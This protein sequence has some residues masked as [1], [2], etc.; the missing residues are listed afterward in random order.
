METEAP[1]PESPRDEPAVRPSTVTSLVVVAETV[2]SKRAVALVT[3][4]A[5]R[6]LMAVPAGLVIGVARGVGDGSGGGCGPRSCYRLFCAAVL[7]SLAAPAGW[8]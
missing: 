1:V 2:S 7:P 5:V 3:V 4:A 8:R 6:T